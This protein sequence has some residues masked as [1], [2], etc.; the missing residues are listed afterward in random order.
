MCLCARVCLYRVAR[1]VAPGRACLRVLRLEWVGKLA[2]DWGVLAPWPCSRPI[3][4]HTERL[5]ARGVDACPTG[6]VCDEVS[7][8]ARQE[9]PALAPAVALPLGWALSVG[10]PKAPVCIPRGTYI[11][12]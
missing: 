11:H 7:Q 4:A 8:C 1:V 10:G 3:A 5:I 6:C 9:V 2:V 12:I